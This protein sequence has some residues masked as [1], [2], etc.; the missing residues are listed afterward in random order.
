MCGRKERK[1]TLQ[2]SL[3]NQ[4][5]FELRNIK[6]TIVLNK[7][8]PQLLSKFEKKRNNLIQRVGQSIVLTVYPSST[9]RVHATGVKNKKDL[10]IIKKSFT[11]NHAKIKHIKIDNTYWLKKPNV[12]NSFHE[13]AQFC[14]ENRANVDIEIDLSNFAM[15]P[16]YPN[17]IYLR[18]KMASGTVI[19]H[20]K[21]IAMLGAKSDKCVKLLIDRVESLLN[22]YN[23]FQR[24]EKGEEGC[25]KGEG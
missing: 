11:S 4:K 18:H 16:Q 14:R 7:L 17:A 22:C 25:A 20:R 13:F 24:D 3:R 2:I 10:R 5:M 19:I 6:C 21:C 23:C 9:N 15:N 12:I 8:T 1:A